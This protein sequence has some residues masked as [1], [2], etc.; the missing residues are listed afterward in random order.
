MEKVNGEKEIVELIEFTDWLINKKDEIY[1]EKL[2]EEILSESN[3]T[4]YLQEFFLK[5]E[6]II[7]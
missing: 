3:D 6:E 4:K 2:E 5:Y 7:K 1:M